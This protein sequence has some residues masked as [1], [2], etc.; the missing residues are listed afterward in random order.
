MNSEIS[1]YKRQSLTE[2]EVIEMFFSE[3]IKANPPI[4][5]PVRIEV[6]FTG[7]REKIILEA[8]LATT[9][10]WLYKDNPEGYVKE[11]IAKRKDK[12]Y[13]FPED[14]VIARLRQEHGI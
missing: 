11:M 1:R 7:S 2:E 14:E 10:L 5:K 13:Q 4:E 9:S 12:D 6:P 8:Y 3:M